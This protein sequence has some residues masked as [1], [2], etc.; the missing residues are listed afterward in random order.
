MLIS[1]LPPNLPTRFRNRRPT[2]RPMLHNHRNTSLP[3]LF[4][5]RRTMPQRRHKHSRIN[6]RNTRPYTIPRTIF[7]RI[8]PSHTTKSTPTPSTRGR[9]RLRSHIPTPYTNHDT[10]RRPILKS[11]SPIRTT[12]P[13]TSTNIQLLIPIQSLL[14]SHLQ[15]PRPNI[16]R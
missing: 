15:Q 5:L 10:N 2:Q 4:L 9:P 13:T 16:P 3:N 1:G 7:L 6:N 14:P 8:T 11:N 12:K